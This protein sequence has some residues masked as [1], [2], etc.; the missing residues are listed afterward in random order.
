MKVGGQSGKVFL[1]MFG[2]VENG[3]KNGT[4]SENYDIIIF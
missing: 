3:K 4:V 2:W 1:D